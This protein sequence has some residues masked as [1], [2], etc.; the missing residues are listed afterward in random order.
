MKNLLNLLNEEKYYEALEG[1]QKIYDSTKNPI[2]LY[3]ITF[4]QYYYTNDYDINE[5]YDNFKTL[6]NYSKE[7]RINS[8]DFYLSFL[9]DNNDY[10][11]ALSVAIKSLK[12]TKQSFVNCYSYSKSLSKL[13][14][15]LDKAQ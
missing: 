1:F 14:K 7:V 3:Y 9:I 4:I 15:Y 12:E 8:Y 5:L 11:L 10:E 2:A 13:N 6:Y